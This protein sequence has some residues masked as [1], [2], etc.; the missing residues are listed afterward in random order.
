MRWQHRGKLHSSTHR[1]NYLHRGWR[2]CRWNW[3]CKYWGDCRGQH[4]I[5]N[6][7]PECGAIVDQFWSHCHFDCGVQS[8]GVRLCLD[9]WYM[10]WHNR[11][12]LCSD[13]DNANDLLC[14]WYQCDRPIN[15]CIRHG[16]R[17]CAYCAKLQPECISCINHL[18]RYFCTYAQLQS[19]R[20]LIC[21]DGW[22][23]RWY[24]GSNL[25]SDTNHHHDLL[26]GRGQ[27]SWH[28]NRRQCH[29]H[30]HAVCTDLHPER[31]S[32]LNCFW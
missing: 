20:N 28:G 30:G 5:A 6:L 11:I 9:G 29:S 23:M 1:I 4:A 18:R 17:D 3:C 21:L 24:H 8:C 22:N 27:S 15:R 14:G 26:S 10:R 2:E 7:H 31:I 25:L 19:C 32:G 13:P 16:Q 12:D